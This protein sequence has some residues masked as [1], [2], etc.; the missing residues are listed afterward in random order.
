[1]FVKFWF[2]EQKN[3]VD[4]SVIQWKMQYSFCHICF[5]NILSEKCIF[6]YHNSH[7]VNVSGPWFVSYD[8]ALS[9]FHQNILK[10]QH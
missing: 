10:I 2:V 4:I 5:D 7:A 8:K 3:K 9:R 1:M 6:C